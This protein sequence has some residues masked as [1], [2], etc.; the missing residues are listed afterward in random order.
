MTE[1]ELIEGIRRHNEKCFDAIYNKYYKLVLY[2]ILKY[3]DNKDDAEDLAVDTF[4]TMY[5]KIDQH[6]DDKSFKY[7]LL[8]IAKNKARRYLG[9]NKN[10]EIIDTEYINIQPDNNSSYNILLKSCSMILTP[11]EFDVLNYHVVFDMTFKDI[12]KICGISQSE[13]F[14][15][16][17]RS[18]LKL[19]AEM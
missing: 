6:S 3:V 10:T 2:V 11:I 17:K 8:T 1:H 19:K 12:S 18:I 16:Y 5:N 9:Q 7:W 13:A 4:V 15:I 14:R